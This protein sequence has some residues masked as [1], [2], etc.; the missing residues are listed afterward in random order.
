MEDKNIYEL[1]I[2]G[3]G[4]AGCGAA[5]YAA[6]KQI[7]TLMILNYWGGQSAVS[8]DIQNWIGTKHISGQE[9]AKNLK[10][11]VLEYQGETLKIKENS[12]VKNISKSQENDRERIFEVEL[13]NSTEKFLAKSILI[14]TGSQ[15]R[16]LGIK[17]ADLFEHKGLT[18]CATCD[19]PLFAKKDMIVVGGG[20]SAFEA[21]A[22][23]LAYAKSVTLISLNKVKAD[24]IMVHQLSKDPKFKIIEN[25]TPREVYG[26]KFVTG[27]TYLN[28]LTKEEIKLKAEAIFVEIGQ[29]PVTDF[30][31]NICEISPDKKIKI[32]PLTQRTSQLGIWA[33]G[34]C[35]N[36]LYHQNNIAVGDGVKAIENIYQYLRAK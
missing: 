4:P 17:G 36:V 34:D 29:I 30:A 18:Y 23:L 3:G 13:E 5:V 15:R 33:A 19:G 32:D 2:I 9:L 11:H 6:R 26:E 25:A 35:T 8:V 31:K 16:R 1:V 21:A 10:D 27:L 7:K 20:N 22:Q 14:A 28:N 12:L 24:P